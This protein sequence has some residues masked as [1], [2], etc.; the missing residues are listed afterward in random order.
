MKF[1]PI[2]AG[3][4]TLLAVLMAAYL[5]QFTDFYVKGAPEDP[6][7]LWLNTMKGIMGPTR[8]VGSVGEYSY[9]RIGDILCSRFKTP[10]AK[11]RL[12]ET[13]PLGEG[14]PYIVTVDMVL[15]IPP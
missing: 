3:F 12:P 6:Q 13:F 2:A 4:L 1:K 15:P 10:T 5:Y 7:G 8:Y 9:F 14:T 11:I